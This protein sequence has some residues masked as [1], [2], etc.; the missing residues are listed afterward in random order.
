MDFN[1]SDE[2][3]INNT[4]GLSSLETEDATIST[5]TSGNICSPSGPPR[6]YKRLLAQVLADNK[7]LGEQIVALKNKLYN[8]QCKNAALKTAQAREVQVRAIE[9]MVG[10]QPKIEALQRELHESEAKCQRAMHELEQHKGFVRMLKSEIAKL[11]QLSTSIDDS[12]GDD[13][14][15]TTRSEGDIMSE[16]QRRRLLAT[17]RNITQSMTKLVSLRDFMHRMFEV[18]KS[19][20][21]LFEDVLELLGSGTEKTRSLADRI[22]AMKFEWDT[23]I[24]EKRVVMDTIEET[25]VSVNGVQTELS[26]WEQ[27]LNETSFRLDVS[28]A[29]NTTECSSVETARDDE[30]GDSPLYQKSMKE[31]QEQIRSQT[32]ETSRLRSIVDEACDTRDLANSAADGLKK[33]LRAQKKLIMELESKLTAAKFSVRPKRAATLKIESYAEP[34]LK[35][36]L[37]RPNNS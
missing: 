15:G 11:D 36:K 14:D 19:S 7:Q 13:S 8:E 32:K 26:A 5:S 27:S 1:T 9:N 35:G 21:I 23:A 6:P 33:E 22:R 30:G 17:E 29:Q 2:Q 20:G 34:K 12:K 24:E 37:R 4:S 31:L 18:L 25:V 3:T 16:E 10:A 28:M